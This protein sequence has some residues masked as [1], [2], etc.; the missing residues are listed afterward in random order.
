VIRKEAKRLEEQFLKQLVETQSGNLTRYLYHRTRNLEVSREIVQEAFFRLTHVKR[1]PEC[2][3]AIPWLYSVCR[4]L[5][6]DYQRKQSKWVINGFEI[7]DHY[8]ASNDPDPL[9]S[10]IQTETMQMLKSCIDH[11]PERHREVMI[12]KFESG[13]SY[14]EISEI[15][16]LSVS[17]VGFIIHQSVARVRYEMVKMV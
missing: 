10:A 8:C 6:I 13:L 3:R 17:N 4:N 12:L 16:Q 7:I 15:T 1:Q 11:L 5:A 9:K 14:K 2:E